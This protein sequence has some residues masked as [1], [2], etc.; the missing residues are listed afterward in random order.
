MVREAHDTDSSW[1]LL[2]ETTGGD[3]DADGARDGGVGEHTVRSGTG[4]RPP[5]A[6]PQGDRRTADR[7]AE[8]FG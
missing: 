3:Q 1:T 6:R 5:Q 2:V 7:A 8:A 4:A